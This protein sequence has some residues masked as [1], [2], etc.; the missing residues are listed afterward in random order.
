VTRKPENYWRD[1]IENWKKSDLSVNAYSKQNG[2]IQ[3][4]LNKKLKALRDQQPKAV[5]LQKKTDK[6]ILPSSSSEIFIESRNLR[7]KLSA[8]VDSSL[9]KVILGEL[10]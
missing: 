10:K 7:I 4:S 6:E 8:T 1:H 5:K 9:L 3:S 2:V